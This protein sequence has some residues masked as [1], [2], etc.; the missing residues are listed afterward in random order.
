[1]A[2]N[3]IFVKTTDCNA[4]DISCVDLD[5]NWSKVVQE[6]EGTN[7]TQRLINAVG[8]F[9]V[10]EMYETEIE[11]DKVFYVDCLEFETVFK[12]TKRVYIFDY[13]SKEKSLMDITSDLREQIETCIEEYVN[14]GCE[15]ELATE[16][17]MFSDYNYIYI[18]GVHVG[19]IDS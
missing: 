6:L 15:V 17:K 12:A 16:I 1:V 8:R 14:F 13:I 9:I 2:D 19:A 10:D 11:Q 18:K 3:I 4:E 7:K 5:Y